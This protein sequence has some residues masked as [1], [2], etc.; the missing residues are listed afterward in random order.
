MLDQLSK[1]EHAVFRY[2]IEGHSP[3]VIA[4]RVGINKKSV[5]NSKARLLNKYGVN[6]K[7]SL[8]L[9]AS[10]LFK[11]KIIKLDESSENA[12]QARWM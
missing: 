3:E 4:E 7:N 10:I 8:L 2:W 9:I 5:L 6:D 11:R 12:P 1:S